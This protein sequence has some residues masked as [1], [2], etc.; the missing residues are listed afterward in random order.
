MKKGKKLYAAIAGGLC[1]ALV[2]GGIGWHYMSANKPE[3]RNPYRE[4]NLEHGNIPLTFTGEGTTADG[5]ITQQPEFDVTAVD[6]II[7]ESYV[8]SEDEV[9]T[10]DPLYK[11]SAESIAEATAYYE[12]QIADASKEQERTRVAYE[13]GKAEAEYTK[14]E[15]KATAASA[16]EVYDAANSTLAQRVTEAESALNEAKNQISVY[17]G[18][19]DGNTYY[20]DA[21]VKGK[22]Q[23]SEKAEE[24]KKEAKKAYNQAKKAYDA[25]VQDV[26]ARIAAL[27]QTASAQAVDTAVLNGLIAELSQANQTLAESQAAFSKVEGEY[28]AAEEAAMKAKEEYN[29]A[30]TTYEKSVSD[31]TARKETLESSLS[32]LEYAYTTAKN[33]EETG[34]VDNKNTYDTAV[35]EGQYADTAYESSISSLEKEYNTATETLTELKEEQSALLALQDGVIT[36]AQDGVL[37]YVSYEAG[38]TLYADT[39]LVGYADTDKLTIAVEVAQ[40]NIA[41]VAVGDTVT[42]NIGGMRGSQLEGTVSTVA[43]EAT[44]G[45]SM[46]NVTYTVEV[47]ID[48]S[49][50]TISTEV[51][52]FVTFSYGEITDVDY[53]MTQALDNIDGTTATVKVY[54]AEGEVEDKIVS[55]GE[56]T[57][58]FTVITEGITA[59]TPCLIEAGGRRDEQE[60]E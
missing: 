37:S 59:D 5:D 8:S 9:K 51:S 36:A 21:D 12:E 22:K 20:K 52:A 38:D 26:N 18:N 6:F 35:L 1:L 3:T 28:Q 2:A 42:V 30:N 10:G 25:A 17:Q 54:N 57:E 45:G 47:L 7:E 31:A 34:K 23:S 43:A 27:Q 32:S 60:A 58:Q 39:P 55:I 13:A 46:S 4:V 24:K 16:Q 11:L 33:A 29:T 49:E 50:G 19:L 41:K 56:S 53:I 14:T 44:S 48:N 15:T 40:E